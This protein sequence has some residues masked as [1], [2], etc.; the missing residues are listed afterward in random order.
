M[1]EVKK[2]RRKRRKYKLVLPWKQNTAQTGNKTVRRKRRRLKLKKEVWYAIAG[3]AAVLLLILVPRAMDNS[4]LKKLGYKKDEIAAIREQKLTRTLLEN[5]WYSPY[6][7]QAIKNN[8]LDKDYLELYTVVSPERG[9][10]A[11]DFL[12]YNR[13][14]DKGYV[15]KQL[16]NLFKNLK[17]W[18]MTPLLVF[19]YQYDETMYIN[20]CTSHRETNSQ[21]HFVLDGNYYTFYENTLPVDDV[22]SVDMLVNK[23]YYLDG[24][25]LPPQLTDLS[26]Q[27]AATD[28]QLAQTAADALADWC[29][30]GRGVGVTFYATSAYRSYES[31]ETLYRNYVGVYGEAQTDLMSA[32]PGFS[33]HQT[34]Y[35]V[36]IAATH[37]DDIEEFKDTL[38]YRWTSTNSPDYGWILRYPEGKESITGYEF[39]SWHYRYLGVDLARAVAASGMTYDEFYCLYLKPWNGEGENKPK[40]SILEAS[41]WHNLI[42][43]E[44]A[45]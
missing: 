12:L 24:S 42:A 41:D 21:D 38:A 9:L 33:E 44:T 32:R 18:E 1:T 10:S 39:E 6:L 8:S 37:E 15:D 4:K 30:A 35:T 40:D 13:L 25:Y 43:A 11:Q 20:D 23:T 7:A 28:R 31:Q 26:I 27:Y 19:D 17:Y 16:L 2:K 36:D 14:L 5:E 3:V 34:G 45:E 22:S 29:N